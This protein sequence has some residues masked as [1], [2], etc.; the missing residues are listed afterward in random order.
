MK[1]E[2]KMSETELSD[3]KK[4]ASNSEP[5]MKIGDDW[6]GLSRQEKAN[7]YWSAMGDKYGFKFMTV[8]PSSKGELYFLAE[9]KPIVKPKTKTEIEIDKYLENMTVKE[10]LKKI[11][12]QLEFCNYE[13]RGGI[14]QNNVAFMALKKLSEVK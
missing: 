6:T 12:R 8:E 10:S 9:P 14:L 4:I 11:I 3:I 2:F 1:Q 5:I 13:C 7:N